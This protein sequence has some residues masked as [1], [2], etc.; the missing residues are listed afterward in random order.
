MAVLIVSVIFAL[1]M[2]GL[3]IRANARFRQETALPMQWRLSRSKPLARSVNWS[4]PRVLALSFTPLLAVCALG[5]F[6]VAAM[7]LTPRSGQE[8]MVI[9]ILI[10]IGSV[11]V[12]AHV[13]HLW[14]IEKTLG[15]NGG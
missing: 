6:N 5:L 2:V 14:L 4:A 13:L 10:F 3:S 11:F 1:V 12:A 7:T 9:P 8:W 15:R